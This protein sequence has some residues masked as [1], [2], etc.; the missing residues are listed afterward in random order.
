MSWDH[1]GG[2][3]IYHQVRINNGEDFDLLMG[4]LNL[5]FKTHE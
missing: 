5:H 1:N 3:L 2:S 4:V